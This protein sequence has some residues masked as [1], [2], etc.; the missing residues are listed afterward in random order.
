MISNTPILKYQTFF[1]RELT[2][3]QRIQL[4]PDDLSILARTVSIYCPSPRNS[5]YVLQVRPLAL[6][7]GPEA[8]PEVEAKADIRPKK[9]V[10]FTEISV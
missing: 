9:V 5:P 1:L 2:H 6:E 4:V 10:R 7:G 8:T 3:F